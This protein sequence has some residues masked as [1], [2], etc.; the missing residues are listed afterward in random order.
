MK[1]NKYKL[2]IGLLMVVLAW[3]NAAS[4]QTATWNVASGNWSNAL[5]WNPLGDPSGPTFNVIC[6]NSGSL[7]LDSSRSIGSY[8]QTGGLLTI[9]NGSTL[10]VAGAFTNNGAIAMNSTGSSNLIIGNGSS[11]GATGTITMSDHPSNQI[12]ARNHGDTLTIAAG[13]SISG[14]GLLNIG[15]FGGTASPFEFRQSRFDRCHTTECT[16]GRYG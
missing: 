13:G 14:A 3:A 2:L 1:K 4:A 15:F 5:N 10:S 8:S 9:P 12:Y 11:L 16:S 6:S 7:N